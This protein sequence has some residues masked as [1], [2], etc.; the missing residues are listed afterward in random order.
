MNIIE[1]MFD[2]F[3]RSNNSSL[4]DEVFTSPMSQKSG[5]VTRRNRL[6]TSDYSSEDGEN[7]ISSSKTD[8][9]S[10]SRVDPYTVRSNGEVKSALQ[11]YKEA[12]EYWK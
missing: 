5:R 2:M 4:S 8:E 12:G 7:E 10:R 1:T 9:S 6:K 11:V 3:Y